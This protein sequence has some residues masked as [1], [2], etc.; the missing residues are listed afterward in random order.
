MELKIDVNAKVRKTDYSWQFG[1][2]SDHAHQVLRKDY[3]EQ[4]KYVH[5][6]LGFRYIR[7]H[8][9]FNDDLFTYSTFR[10]FAPMPGDKHSVIENNFAQAGKVY[11]NVLEAGFKPF[12]ELSFMPK[13]LAKKI[14][15]GLNYVNDIY[16]PKDYDLWKK[17]IQNFI[18]FLINRYGLNEVRSWYFEVWNEP[19]LKMFFRGKQKDYFKMYEVASK[20][21]KE[22]D[23]D[24]KVGGPSTSGC[25][26]INEFISFCKNNNVPY[27]F[28]STHH[29]PG[30]GFGNFISA[31]DF[32]R[33]FKTMVN[34][35]KNKDKLNV[36]LTKMFFDSNKAKLVPKGIL[37]KLDGELLS[38]TK[39]TP[40]IVSEWNSMAIFGAYIHDEK[41][42]ASFLLKSVLDLENKFE[43]YMF[44]CISDI[45]EELLQL[46][47]PFHGGFGLLTIDGIPKPSFW[48]FKILSMLY[49]KRLDLDFRSQK[50][51]EYAVFKKDG[52]LQILLYAQNNDPNK[53]D[54]FDINIEIN[55]IY[56]SAG[57]QSI[58]DDYTNPKKIWQEL[59]S[60][61]NLTKNE[62]KYIID[63]SC[64]VSRKF[65]INCKD[66][67]TLFR[68]SLKTNDIQLITL[69]K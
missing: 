36:A 63:K 21:I 12:V 59:G 16:P 19:N 52:N 41:Y 53:N 44:W 50:D 1:I 31:K 56:N 61:A 60:K 67:K 38:K 40:T 66:N 8:G 46:N 2:G 4:M 24:L 65:N 15:N 42:S 26:W 14:G 69:R 18:N 49:E 25:R 58:D 34:S 10:D 23:P 68:T 13:N 22:I 35:Q 6:Q 9:I 45:F 39:G 57:I 51:V 20:A 11:D 29:Y 5:D 48:A 47:E 64:L 32:P 30:D 55:D 37:T 43:G 28:V 17:Y 62:V 27:D 54:N 7:F 33:I 3:F